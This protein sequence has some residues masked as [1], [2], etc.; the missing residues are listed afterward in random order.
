MSEISEKIIATPSTHYGAGKP[1]TWNFIV[2]RA[3]G[4]LNIA[5]ALFFIYLVVRLAR[6]DAGT[7]S[8]LLS[9]PIVAIVTALMIIS[10]TMH[11][12]IG[13]REVI[14]DYVHDEKLNRFCLMLNWLVAIAIAVVTLAALAKLVFW[15]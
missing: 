12:R 1:S 5:F 7:M 9:N 15:G 11:M 3:T 13:M 2:Q 6:A 4:A 10:A 8:D 14:E